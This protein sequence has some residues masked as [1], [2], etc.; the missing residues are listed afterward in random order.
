MDDHRLESLFGQL[1]AR[2]PDQRDRVQTANQ[3]R[4]DNEHGRVSLPFARPHQ[5][6]PFKGLPETALRFRP[7]RQLLALDRRCLV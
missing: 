7:I 6:H 5:H 1:R 2:R 3:C 4:T